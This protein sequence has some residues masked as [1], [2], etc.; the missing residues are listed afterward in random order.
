MDFRPALRA[1]AFASGEGPSYN[2][3]ADRL[4]AEHTPAP[5][6][7]EVVLGAGRGWPYLRDVVMPR[8]V[9]FLHHKRRDPLRG[10][11]VVVALFDGDRFDLLECEAL[12]AAY[13]E[14]EDLDG[15]GFRARVTDWLA[16]A[17][18]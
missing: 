13:R 17:P 16:K 10:E 3:V 9:A 7:Y 12:L 1:R 14:L 4:R 15:A 6:L 11:G 18:V 2:R 8:L 5:L